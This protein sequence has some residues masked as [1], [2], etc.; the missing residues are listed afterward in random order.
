M[1]YLFIAEKPSSMREFASVY[2]KH[3]AE[4][5]KIVG[6][7]IEFIAL[8]G[9]IFRN[10]E[11]KEY[12]V[13]DK[14]W[15][16]LYESDLPMI[17]SNWKIRPIARANDAIKALKEK[18]KENF[19]GIIVGTDSDVEGYGIYYMVC[20][21]MNLQKYKTLRFY[22]TSLTERD[23]L[24]SFLTM[25]DFF[26]T[27][28][29]KNAT[30]AFVFRN[31]WDWLIG[32]NLST[33]Y[34]V[35]FGELIR[36]G[37]VKAPT[38][39]L[40]YDNC[41]AIDNFKK[42]TT[43]AVKSSFHDG[44]DAFLME[45]DE[46][47]EKT[48][49]LKTDAD[50]LISSLGNSAVVK[51]FERKNNMTAPPKLYSLSDLQ[52]DAAKQPL[53]YSPDKTLQIA[54][55]LYEERK[56]LTYPR[57]SGTHLATA[58]S[59]DMPDILKSIQDIPELTTFITTITPAKIKQVS[60]NKNIFNDAEVAKASHDALIPT[61]KYVDWNAL[62]EEEQNVFLL[63][64]KRLVSHFLNYFAEEK[65]VVVL[66]NN[67]EMFKATG[68]KT[69]DNGYNDLYG[70]TV[71]DVIIKEYSK[72][73]SVSVKSNE[74]VERVSAPPSRYT[75]GTIIKAMKNIANEVKDPDLK[76]R[77]KES[78]GIGTEATRASILKDLST[79]G[80]ISLKKN[81]IYITDTGRS[82]IENIRVDNG[83]GT[84]DYGIADP[85]NVAYWSSKNKEIQLGNLTV[86]SALTEFEEY[87][88]KTIDD[89][90]KSGTPV[91]N[92]S[93]KSS[94]KCPL[95]GGDVKSGKFGY[96]CENYKEKGCP[97]SIPNEIAKKKL[98]EKQKELLLNGKKIF[99]DG[100]KSKANKSFG[101]NLQLG[102]DGKV[103][104]TFDN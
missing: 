17:P 67:G 38:L 29:H 46:K 7:D 5:K 26:S 28:R 79:S 100:L 20:Q 41:N 54:Q 85:V 71:K 86:E 48:F 9:H 1:K 82:Y 44:F 93:S 40:I 95:C 66:E 21:A 39:K 4:I 58:K 59:K 34:T 101:A 104:M 36:F 63:V 45:D 61:G 94:H 32:M 11:P 70:K 15:A 19:D 14:K 13:W 83:D 33:A 103:K 88:R 8:R 102:D 56:I 47:T 50:Q 97:L 62:T 91:K 76:K 89:L 77:M 16:D 2:N 73:D 51:S 99:V 69:L 18:L 60:S 30:A 42:T 3:S 96:Y 49:A 78:E 31:R 43:Y 24:K 92:T 90:K 68:R 65:T 57:T 12:D 23:I 87:L 80:Y 25:E 53:E 98:T 81:S 55:R 37:S 72:G 22:E 27:P 84:F 10:M 6:G 64:C 52:I 74:T 75:M 35:R